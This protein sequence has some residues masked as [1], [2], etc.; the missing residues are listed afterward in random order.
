MRWLVPFLSI[1]LWIALLSPSFAKE[2]RTDDAPASSDAAENEDV[3]FEDEP[4]NEAP[5]KKEDEDESLSI[6]PVTVRAARESRDLRQDRAASGS[7]LLPEDFDDAGDDMADVLDQEAGVR[8]TKLGGPASFSTLSIRGSTS[9]QVSV[10]LDGIPLNSAAGG[11][12]DLSRIPLGNIER[13]EIYRG[14]APLLFGGSAIGGAVSVTTRTARN[15]K[16]TLSGGGGS[17]GERQARTF[18]AEP[19]DHWDL[20][21]GLDY[22]GWE[23][24]FPYENDNG[25]RFDT[26]DDRTVTRRNN[27]F[28]QINLLGKARWRPDRNWTLTLMEWF[29]WRDQGVPGLGQFE[30]EKSRHEVM[31]SLSVLS[32]QGRKLAGLA[33]WT[34]H[35]GFRA[36]QSAFRDPLEEIGL[37]SDDSEDRSLSPSFS[38]S[39][40]VEP[41]DWWDITGQFGYRYERFEPSGGGLSAARSRRHDLSA[42]LESGF[43]IEAADLLIL[44]SGRVAWT[45]SRLAGSTGVGTGPAAN[46][47]RQTE[48]SFRGALVNQ[49]VPDT[50]LTVSGGRAVRLPSLFELFGNSGRVIG[51]P[52]LKSESAYNVDGGIVYDSRMLPEP[53]RLRLELYGFYSDVTDLIQFVQTAQNVSRAENVDRAR[54]WGIEAGLRGDL[55]GHLRVNGNY[56]YLNAKNTGEIRARK[57]RHLPFRPAGKWYART[58]GYVADLPE[59]AELAV[60]LDAEWIAGNFL[61]NA[62]LVAVDER[63]YLNA[64]LSVELV[65]SVARLS[66]TAGNL[67]DE[68]TADLAGYPLPGRSFHF[69]LTAKV[70]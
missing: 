1:G 5:A 62:N 2:R 41:A 39:L 61:D 44:P 57:D 25:T 43:L 21:L 29:F 59:F 22:G 27:R 8:V 54:L 26:S 19:H 58:E 60:F 46:E 69:L 67:T 4:G 31:D 48:W 55:F 23:G 24:T 10:I 28:D 64:G 37:T 70:L 38:S 34:L 16:L 7:V 33:S 18:Y 66:F 42:G 56:S 50:K 49:S 47:S 51:N 63:F 20:A 30:T 11:P 15:R 52:N 12:V 40:R 3:F 68:R 36:T 17:F 9:D 13:V 14:T 35:A 6:A 65:R 45:D 53:Y 32:V